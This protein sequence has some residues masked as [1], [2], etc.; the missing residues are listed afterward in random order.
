MPW[1]M[2]PCEAPPTMDDSVIHFSEEQK[3]PSEARQIIIETSTSCE[4]VPISQFMDGKPQEHTEQLA[5]E[6]TSSKKG[7]ETTS[8]ALEVGKTCKKEEWIDK[9]QMNL[10][11]SVIDKPKDSERGM[12]KSANSAKPKT[13][14]IKHTYTCIE[15]SKSFNKNSLLK[16]HQ[17]IHREEKPYLCSD[18]GRRFNRNL[19]LIRHQRTHTG[20]K[21]Y[22]CPECGKSFNRNSALFRHQRTHTGDKQYTCS[23]CDRCF[24]LNSTLINHQ[25][26][27]TG[28][29]PYACGECGKR[30]RKNS[31]LTC[32]QRTHT[33]DKP[34]ACPECGKTFML[35]STLINHKRMHTGEKP[36]ACTQCG[37]R[38][39]RNSTLISHQK[40]HA[41]NCSSVVNHVDD[42]TTARERN[43][44]GTANFKD[45]VMYNESLKD[46]TN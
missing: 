43:S 16:A 6:N 12:C 38:F 17:R 33:G 35:N 15:C 46:G 30:F 37:R 32:H 28:E 40:K 29:K 1:L 2:D 9:K 11:E 23:Q 13:H 36:Y 14:R 3:Q 19:T 22:T 24:M 27:H 4:L 26:I 45:T 25:R 21:P 31:T 18:C 20:E 42:F 34:Y 41:E 10:E 44:E 39:T 5:I 8:P 7:Q